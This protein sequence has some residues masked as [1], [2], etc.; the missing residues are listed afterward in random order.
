MSSCI[1]FP[2]G[3]FATAKRQ[4]LGELGP[5]SHNTHAPILRMAR[6]H[7]AIAGLSAY[8]QGRRHD[9]KAEPGGCLLPRRFIHRCLRR[10]L[11]TTALGA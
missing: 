7:S 8:L 2:M 6:M 9:C 11:G 10:L 1:R 3:K 5:R 4:K